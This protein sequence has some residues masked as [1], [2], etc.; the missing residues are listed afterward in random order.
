MIFLQ[1]ET[2]QSID[3]TKFISTNY[4]SKINSDRLK[5]VNATKEY[6]TSIMHSFYGKQ[7]DDITCPTNFNVT[8]NTTNS[9]PQY[10][11]LRPP[12]F[13]VTYRL[14]K[15]I[16]N[17]K[18]DK[19]FFVSTIDTYNSLTPDHCPSANDFADD[20]VYFYQGKP[21]NIKYLPPGDAATYSGCGGIINYNKYNNNFI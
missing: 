13:R 18:Y 6:V 19:D 5:D 11:Y 2:A 8:L 4:L 21:H 14:Y 10:L 17:Y 1:L 20:I 16:L 15:T 12:Y 7:P 9:I 3:M